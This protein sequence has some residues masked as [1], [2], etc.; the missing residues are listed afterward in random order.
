MTLCMNCLKEMSCITTGQIIRY[1]TGHCYSGDIKECKICGTRV[2]ICNSTPFH[3]TELPA[4][5]IPE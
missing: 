1:G 2:I 3:N 5:S 4:I